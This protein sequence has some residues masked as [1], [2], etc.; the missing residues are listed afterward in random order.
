M[1][2]YNSLIVSSVVVQRFGKNSQVKT[3]A[4]TLFS[5]LWLLCL[6]TILCCV[7]DVDAVTVMV[8]HTQ[9]EVI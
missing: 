7:G 2:I 8:A 4:F 3:T 1:S 6:S 9:T 5:V